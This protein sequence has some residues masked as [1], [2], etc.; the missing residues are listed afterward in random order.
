MYALLRKTRLVRPE[1]AEEVA[2]RV[3]EDA[4]PLLRAQPGFR[5]HLGFL[6]EAGEAVGVSLL[7][8]RAAAQAA[9]GRLRAWAAVGLADLAMG[10]PE[11]RGGVVLHL[12]SLA[13]AFGGEGETLFVTV[14]QYDGVGASEAAVR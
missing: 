12:G 4:V 6:S 14:R 3:R 2:R 11:V 1:T 5:L 13:S 9:L 8:D 7:E 10:E